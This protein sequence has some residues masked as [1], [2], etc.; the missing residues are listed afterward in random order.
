MIVD[1]Q[2][3]LQELFS[4]ELI[5]EG[6]N[7]ASVSDAQS[8]KR[9]VEHSNPDLVLLDLYLRGFEGWDV[10]HD[11]KHDAP[12]IP[13]LILTAYDT[14]VNDSRVSQADGYWVNSF[15]HLDDLKQKIADVL[16][17]KKKESQH[18]SYKDRRKMISLTVSPFRVIRNSRGATI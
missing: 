14:Y 4:Q 2:P 12:N 5:T 6:Y 18:E 13:V 3:H 9:Y 16:K 17:L 10:L 7:V 1:D 8:A 11:I 15:I